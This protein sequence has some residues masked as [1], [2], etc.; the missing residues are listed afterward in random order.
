MTP[1]AAHRLKCLKRFRGVMAARGIQPQSKTTS[2][3]KAGHETGVYRFSTNGGPCEVWMDYGQDAVFIFVWFDHPA[4][5]L[6]ASDKWRIPRWTLLCRHS[7]KMNEYARIEDGLETID[8]LLELFEIAM[9]E[10]EARPGAPP[11]PSLFATIPL[12]AIEAAR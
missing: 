2:L 9:R 1:D 11:L 5:A 10:F 3:L 7:G 8:F 12:P 6:D 4:K